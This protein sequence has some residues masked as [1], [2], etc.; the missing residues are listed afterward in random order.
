MMG[1]VNVYIFGI[2]CSYAITYLLFFTCYQIDRIGLKDPSLEDE[3]R[4][5]YNNVIL[6]YKKSFIPENAQR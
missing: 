1:L 3:V 6:H 5:R 2:P 4:Y